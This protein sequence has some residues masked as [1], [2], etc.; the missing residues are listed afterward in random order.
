MSTRKERKQVYNTRQWRRLR[1]R[2]LDDQPF[3][4]RC[5]AQGFVNGA[6]MVHHRKPIR[7]GGP[8]FPELDGLESLCWQCHHERHSAT[9]TES[10]AAFY[11]LLQQM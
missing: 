10:Q 4:E 8:A 5:Q 7:D 9:L 2:K 11:S 3:C 1:D 6:V